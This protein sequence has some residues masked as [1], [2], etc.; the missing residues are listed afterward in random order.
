ML[1]KGRPHRRGEVN[2]QP[3]HGSEEAG[4]FEPEAPESPPRADE[5]GRLGDRRLPEAIGEEIG[6]PAPEGQD[7]RQRGEPGENA[8]PPNGH[9]SQARTP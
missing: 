9:G 7:Q 5:R 8:S 4:D 1:R 2:E 6:D 3:E